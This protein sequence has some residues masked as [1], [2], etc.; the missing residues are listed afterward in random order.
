MQ[1]QWHD[2]ST[3]LLFLYFLCSRHA[4]EQHKDSSLTAAHAAILHNV[5]RVS[6]SVGRCSSWAP[7]ADADTTSPLL[8]W[9]Q[10]GCKAWCL[11]ARHAYCW[12][13]HQGSVLH[14]RYGMNRQSAI[15]TVNALMHKACSL[16]I[17]SMTCWEMHTSSQVF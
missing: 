17:S 3:C 2:S 6:F 1:K 10:G 4:S 9:W 13:Y 11:P 7:L 12:W 15:L 16:N 14:K 5:T 8:T